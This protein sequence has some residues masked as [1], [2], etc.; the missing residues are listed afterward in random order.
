M[1]EENKEVY[2]GSVI[3]FNAGDGYVFIEWSKDNVPQRDIFVHFSDISA[4]GFRTLKKNQRV[5]FSIGVNNK[6]VDKAIEVKALD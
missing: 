1:S 2:V 6:G 3:W 4:S 5:E